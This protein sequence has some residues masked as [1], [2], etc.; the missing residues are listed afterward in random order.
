MVL[1]WFQPSG[2]VQRGKACTRAHALAALQK[3]PWGSGILEIS[4]FTI[5]MCRGR[6]AETPLTF[7]S[8][9]GEVPDDGSARRSSGELAGR[10]I[11][12]RT[13]A[14]LRSKPNSRP[15]QRFP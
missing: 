1:G 4:S 13:D 12:E 10:S 15:N 9:T 6:I 14:L 7:Y 8:F 5:P 3:G 2:P 11:G